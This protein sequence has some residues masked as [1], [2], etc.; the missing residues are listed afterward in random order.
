M[1]M[2]FF[3]N[4]LQTTNGGFNPSQDHGVLTGIVPLTTTN[5]D[6]GVSA[7]LSPVGSYCGSALTND[8]L[9]ISVKL[10]N[11]GNTQLFACNINYELDNSGLIQTIA[12]NGSLVQYQPTSVTFSN[13]LATS[14]THTIVCWSDTPDGGVDENDANDTTTVIFTVT[15]SAALPVMEGFETATSLPNS[16]WN[17]S[18]TSTTGGVDFVITSAAAATGSKSCMIDNMNNIAGNNSIIQ[19]AS[20]YNMTTFTTPS[21][22]FKAAYQ[23][24]AT[25]NTDKL[26]I[27]T[28]TDCGTTWISRRVI[29]SATLAS[30]AGGTGTSSYVPTPAQFTTYT[31]SMVA[32]AS[33]TNVMFRWEF[34][35]DPISPGNNLYI[36]DINIVQSTA[37]I[38]SI[39]ESVGLNLYPN[40]SAGAVNI[41]FNLSEQHNVSITVTDMLGRSVETIAS[42][43]YQSGE[44][45]LTIGA[46]NIYQAGVYLVNIDIDGQHISKKIIM[47]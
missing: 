38:E 2:D 11:F 8:S 14:G 18:H 13:I 3:I 36:D 25:T 16:N 1:M 42:K 21:L 15:N 45:T 32:V 19:T 26:L 17:I 7:I 27:Y 44:T 33:N 39:E 12:W 28:S 10:Q 37:G 35:A 24:K 47:Q 31:V 22:S 29:T 4:N 5:Y 23:Q 34:F 43:S 41:D 40:P 9:S 20:T 6:A 46:N 30:L